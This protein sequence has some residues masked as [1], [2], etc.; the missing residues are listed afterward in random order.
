MVFPEIGKSRVRKKLLR[1]FFTNPEVD[2]YLREAAM[3]LKED[4]GNLS[5]ELSGLEKMGIFNSRLSGKQKYFSLNK[6][7]LLYKELKSIISKTIGFEGSLKELINITEGIKTAF[8][9]GSFAQD[10]ENTS[11]DIDL[12]IIGHPD[13]GVFMEKA[14][15]LEKKLGREI[16]YNIYSEK[17]FKERLK[18][19]DSFILNILKRPKIIL[20]GR[21]D[22]F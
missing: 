17:E 6:Q 19:K 22:E 14:D 11:S 13:E 12:L 2:I 18:H 20:Q 7:Y 1:Y 3:I 16:N 5:R 4:P 8:I 10:K 21:L 9:Y 15:E